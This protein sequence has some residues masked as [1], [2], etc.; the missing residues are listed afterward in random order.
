[1]EIKQIFRVKLMGK[2]GAYIYVHKFKNRLLGQNDSSCSWS[3]FID[4]KMHP[5]HF[6]TLFSAFWMHSVVRN[7][8]E[9]LC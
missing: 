1:M 9:Q 2:P 7:S 5:L 3:L 6:Q 4:N 8:S